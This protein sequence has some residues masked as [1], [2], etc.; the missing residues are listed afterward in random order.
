MADE[1]DFE[2]GR[3]SN[4]QRH[5]T[6]TLTL[7]WATRHTVVHHSSTSTYLPNFIR[8]EKKLFVDGGH[9]YGQTSRPALDYRVDITIY[10]IYVKNCIVY[11]N[12]VRVTLWLEI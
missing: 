1:I 10:Y 12:S 2:N 4:F 11:T 6:L 3:I 9:M 7:D 8:I 5:M